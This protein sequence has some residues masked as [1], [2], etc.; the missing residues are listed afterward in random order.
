LHDV[1]LQSLSAA[2]QTYVHRLAVKNLNRRVPY[3][4]QNS[5]RLNKLCKKVQ[6]LS[7]SQITSTDTETQAA[8]K[9][10]LEDYED[11]WPI[12][13]MLRVHLRR[14]SK[15]YAKDGRRVGVERA[16]SAE[17]SAPHAS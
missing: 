12:R 16:Q 17:A 5:Q 3:E 13:W 15:F 9:F 2:T 10:N 1:G 4:Q 7:Y 14:S 6:V 8:K 11:C